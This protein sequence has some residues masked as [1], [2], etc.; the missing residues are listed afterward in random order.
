MSCWVNVTFAP[1]A[2]GQR[3]ALLQF[4][5]NNNAVNNSTQTV[6]LSGNGSGPIVSISGAP[7]VFG[8]QQVGTTSGPAYVYLSNLGNGPLTIASV[9]PVN[10]GDFHVTN[11]CPISPS[12]LPMF[13]S[14]SVKITFTPSAVGTSTASFTF[15]DDDNAS[16]GSKQKVT[17]TGTGTAGTASVS[18][19]SV[20]FG[21]VPI[22]T[23]VGPMSFMISNTGTAPLTVQSIG[24][25]PTGEFTETD[26][27]VGTIAIGGNC[28]VMVKFTP[29]ATGSRTAVLTITDNSGGCPTCFVTQT[30]NLSGT[31]TSFSISVSPPTLTV[32]PGKVG[33]YT[34]TL[35]PISGFS[36]SV[37]LT[38]SVASVPPTKP[39]ATTCTVP[40][41]TV[42][43]SG[44]SQKHIGVSAKP[45]KG[46]YTLTFSATYTATPP[47]VG[48]LSPTPATA[49]LI[50]K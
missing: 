2:E 12:T 14:C 5:D 31:G 1:S 6:G 32:S 49:Q 40:A 39:N 15:T 27:C 17:L 46:T 11:S 22:T 42:T 18:T 19:G 20:A 34:V 28:T 8:S 25:A 13:G 45:K 35:N 50:S 48:T 4:T 30:V 10:P 23:T 36:G 7:V 44:G 21:A 16:P 41:G 24:I 37:T 3:S 33:L 43:I 47:A 9:G 26:N 29:S 38:C